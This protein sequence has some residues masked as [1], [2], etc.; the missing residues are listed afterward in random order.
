MKRLTHA[1][2]SILNLWFMDDGTIGDKFDVLLEDVEKVLAFFDESGLTLNTAKCEVFFIN[3]PEVDRIEMLR[4]LNTL[5]PGIKLIDISSFQLLG[6]PILDEGVSAILSAGLDTVKTMC[7]RLT[8]LD[9]HPALRVLRSSISSPRFQYILRTSPTFI[10]M[11]RL[12]EIDEFYRRTLE[13][14]TNNKLN[15]KSWTQASLPLGFA[16]LGIRKLVHLA[17]PAYFSSWYQS[18]DLSNQMLA[19]AN[20]SVSNERFLSML[21]HY[22]TELTP[23]SAELR[24]SQKAWDILKVTAIH[25]ELL[26]SSSPIE[27]ARLLASSSKPASKWLHAIPSHQLGLLLDNDSARIAVALRLGNKVCEPHVCICGEMVDQYGYHALSCNKMK[28]KYFRHM[29]INKIFS[30]AF[31]AATFPNTLEPYGISRRD[32][33]RPDGLTSYPWSHGKSLIWDVT[34]VNTVAASYV[35]MTSVK[36]GAAADQAERGKHNLYIDLKQDYIFTP[37]AFETFGSIGP[38]TE[39]F[40]RKLGKLMEKYTGEPRSLDFLQQRISISI[41]RANAISIRDSHC[42][43]NDFNVFL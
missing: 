15:D 1:L 5:L 11:D 35:N 30:M 34:V 10:Q 7:K 43:N 12:C 37:L 28:A 29:D 17:H 31:I 4:K 13:A 18:E 27:R 19:K 9:I 8:L 33:K 25:E 21:D 26:L 39:E 24:K 40:M 16:G 20:L 38:E 14:V 41:Q 22:P 3:T 32:G 36:S 6:A 2:S 23:A 42:D